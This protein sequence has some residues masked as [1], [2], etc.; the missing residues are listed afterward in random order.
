MI[1]W[2]NLIPDYHL[3]FVCR[4]KFLTFNYFVFYLLYIYLTLIGFKIATPKFKG[5]AHPHTNLKCQ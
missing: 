3:F 5:M 4:E 2:M 1:L